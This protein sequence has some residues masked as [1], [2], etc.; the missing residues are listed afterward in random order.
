MQFELSAAIGDCGTLVS[1]SRLRADLRERAKAEGWNKAF[2]ETLKDELDAHEDRL[3]RDTE[4]QMDAETE[5][6]ALDR[7]RTLGNSLVQNYTSG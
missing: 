3:T 4:R 7:A 6:A 2:M 1:L 5:A